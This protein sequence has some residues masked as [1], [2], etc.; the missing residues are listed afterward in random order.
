[1]SVICIS[2][3]HWRQGLWVAHA[4]THFISPQIL[5]I[6]RIIPILKRWENSAGSKLTKSWGELRREL[7]F[8]P[9]CDSEA[10]N[11]SSL[12]RDQEGIKVSLRVRQKT[13]MTWRSLVAAWGPAGVLGLNPGFSGPHCFSYCSEGKTILEPSPQPTWGSFVQ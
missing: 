3:G 5:M 13:T 12:H 9:G 1:M 2:G 8:E 4:L 6:W 7:G 11:F 10:H